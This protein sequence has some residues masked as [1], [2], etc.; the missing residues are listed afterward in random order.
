MALALCVFAAWRGSAAAEERIVKE[1][2][3]PTYA[4]RDR[5]VTCHSEEDG[6]GPQ[7]GPSAAR[8][9]SASLLANHPTGE[10]GCAV[11]HA[12]DPLSIDKQMAHAGDEEGGQPILSGLLVQSRC[13]R[14][15]QDTELPGTEFLR[16]GLALID[17]RACFACHELPAGD[18]RERRAPTLENIANKVHPEWLTA[19]LIDP[20]DYSATTRMPT[21]E[22]SERQAR[23]IASYL[24]ELSASAPQPHAPMPVDE[25]ELDRA[26]ARRLL[27]RSACLD[28]HRM[29]GAGGSPEIRAPDLSRIGDKVKRSW[30]VEWLKGPQ[31]LQPGAGMP[32]FRFTDAQ[33]STLARYLSETFTTK[34]RSNARPPSSDPELVEEGKWLVAGFGCMNCHGAPGQKP[35]VKPGPDLR[36]VGDRDVKG[37]YWPRMGL[38]WDMELVSYL[39]AKVATPRAFGSSHKMPK[40]RF[41]PDEVEAIVV[42]LLSFSRNPIPEQAWL[43]VARAEAALDPPTGPA[44]AVFQR[45]Q[46]LQCHALRGAYGKLAPDLGWEGDSVYREWLIGFLKNPTVIRPGYD[47]RMPDFGMTDEEVEI[48]ADYIEATWWHEEVPPDPFDGEPAPLELVA[49]GREL[50][51]DEYGCLDC[52][53]MGEEGEVDGPVLTEVGDRLQPGWIYQWVLD[54]QR[55][56]ESDMDEQGVTEEDALALTAYLMSLRGERAD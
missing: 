30:L 5:C 31:H 34:R 42:A 32:S 47:A 22:L 39:R 4:I 36:E 48:V 7:A 52:H 13:L 14:C 19:W 53:Q 3:N 54:P 46:C 35:T 23:A 1:V 17:D 56:Y 38:D 55:F 51:R 25:G 45:Y 24:M 6:E 21:F 50:L 49:R 43:R 2:I 12:G 20:S 28:C 26:E 33:V 16:R 10:L 8:F 27:K 29:R 9:H 40:F 15:H 37:L 44:A 18:R 11:C 41:A